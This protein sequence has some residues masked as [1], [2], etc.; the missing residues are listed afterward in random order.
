MLELLGDIFVTGTM[1]VIPGVKASRGVVYEHI[2]FSPN[3]LEFPG[4]HIMGEADS[5]DVVP[6]FFGADIALTNFNLSSSPWVATLI[7]AGE[8]RERAWLKREQVIENIKGF[9]KA[10]KTRFTGIPSLSRG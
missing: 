2:R 5:L 3:G 4:E 10:S 9:L 6:D 8:S 1:P 7:I